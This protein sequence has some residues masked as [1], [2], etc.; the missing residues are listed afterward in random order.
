L[1]R[2]GQPDEVAAALLCRLSD[3]AS[4]ATGAFIDLDGGR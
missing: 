3:E 2:G 1:R 4:Y